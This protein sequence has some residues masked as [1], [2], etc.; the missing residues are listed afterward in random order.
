MQTRAKA[1]PHIKKLV[2]A[3]LH[4]KALDRLKLKLTFVSH[5]M[6]SG[7]KVCLHLVFL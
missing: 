1:V 2:V 6:N 7:R 3:D 5:E 4:I